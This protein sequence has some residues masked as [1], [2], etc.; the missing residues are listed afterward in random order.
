MILRQI[1]CDLC[2]ETATEQAPGDGWPG[3][4]ELKGVVLNGAHNPCLCPRH[5]QI[6]WLALTTE[7][8]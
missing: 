3:W 8:A 6:A 4:G 1:K 2:E 5:L 7:A